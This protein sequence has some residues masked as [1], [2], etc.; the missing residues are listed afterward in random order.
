MREKIGN[1]SHLKKKQ[2]THKWWHIIHHYARFG[3]YKSSWLPIRDQG[4]L[5]RMQT[6]ISM[7]TVNPLLALLSKAMPR[8]VP[9]LI[10]LSFH[11][12]GNDVTSLVCVTCAHSNSTDMYC[13][14]K[15]VRE[16]GRIRCSTRSWA[17][18]SCASVTTERASPLGEP[19]NRRSTQLRFVHLM[20]MLILHCDFSQFKIM[21]LLLFK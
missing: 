17:R 1:Q 20:C 5:V 15:Q 13:T 8:T 11:W 16:V 4:C 9:T 19:H 21:H 6:S 2:K 14:K 12:K 18:G 10:L 7:A 3:G